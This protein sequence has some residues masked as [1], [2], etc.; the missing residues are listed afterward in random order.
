MSRQR[1]G[2]LLGLCML[3]ACAVYEDTARREHDPFLVDAGNEPIGAVRE[4]AAAD[5]TTSDERD[6]GPGDAPVVRHDAASDT[7]G[8]EVGAGA[9]EGG[10]G[11]AD[12]LWVE[13]GSRDVSDA[14]WDVRDAA[15]D[16]TG[17]TCVVAFTVTG[18][19]GDGSDGRN[20]GGTE[21]GTGWLSTYLVGDA[22]A[23]G[24]WAPASGIVMIEKSAGTWSTGVVLSQGARIEFKF[25]RLAD[26]SPPQWESWNPYDSNRSMVIDCFGEGGTH[27]ADA[28]DA[29]SGTRPAVGTS[30][31]GVFGV[32]PPDAT[33]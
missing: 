4:D 12:A 3:Q 9:E 18:V 13:A 7:R 1:F 24:T 20:D 19:G 6:L 29:A 5:V 31:S 10:G 17:L 25:V 15:V 22:V 8:A 2:W 14:A 27:D 11:R 23:L 21:A 26:G 30:Y 28:S 32:R 33:K 16:A